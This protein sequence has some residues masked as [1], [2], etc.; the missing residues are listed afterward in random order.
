MYRDWFFFSA[1]VGFGNWTEAMKTCEAGYLFG[2]VDLQNAYLACR[3]SVL[4]SN[5]SLGWI[6]VAKQPYRS[7]DIGE[8]DII[9]LN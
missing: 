7:E 6:G 4:H 2:D 1:N 9:Y 8:C 3:K 5:V